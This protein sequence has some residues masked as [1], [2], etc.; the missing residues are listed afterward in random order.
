MSSSYSRRLLVALVSMAALLLAA[1]SDDDSD[2]SGAGSTITEDLSAPTTESGGTETPA[3]DGEPAPPPDAIDD[4]AGAAITLTPVAE[5]DA[6]I[7]LVARPGSANLFV[8]ERGGRVQTLAPD[9]NG[10]WT[11]GQVVVD[12]S[13]ETTT[14]VERGLLG[15]AFD[16]AGD[17]IYVSFTD[18]AGDSRVDE[19]R[20]TDN[21]DGAAADPGSRRTVYTHDQPYPNHNGGHIAFGPD[22]L[23]YL[24]LGDGG[25]GGDPLGAG[26]DPDTALGS[27]IRFDPT[28]D[29]DRPFTIPADN[30]FAD[31]GGQPEIF[32]NGVRNP[33]RFSWDSQ[34]GDLWIADVGQGAVEEINWLPG[35]DDASAGLGANLGWAIFEGDER[36]GPGDEPVGYVGPIFTYGHGPGCSITGG[37]VSR[38]PRIPALFGAYLYSDYCDPAI[39]AVLQ[40]DGE[41]IDNRSLDVEVPGGQM[42]SFGEGPDGE[43]YVLSLSGGVFRIDTE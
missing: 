35:G 19:W 30:P 28:P 15:L 24:A 22:G 13:G 26:Q 38:D 12:I 17:R 4:L 37:F 1:C 5:F 36:F 32:I 29:G 41:V 39:H 8:A 20:L 7:A 18:G 6:P 9:G 31:G 21:A 14:D 16:P 34:T 25:G 42:V 40:R 3:T 11:P 33:W 27:I 23:L 2:D 43:L 10:G